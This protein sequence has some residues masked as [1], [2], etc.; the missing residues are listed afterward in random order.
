MVRSEPSKLVSRS[1]LPSIS[2]ITRGRANNATRR[3]AVAYIPP[4]KQPILPA[5]AT[6]I[7]RVEFIPLLHR[8]CSRIDSRLSHSPPVDDAVCHLPRPALRG[9]RVRVRG[10]VRTSYGRRVRLEPAHPKFA[11][12]NFD[13]S[14]QAGRGEEGTAALSRCPPRLVTVTA[15]SYVSPGAA[16]AQEPTL[17]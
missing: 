10:C 8:F 11:S 6:P 15:G 7:G 4:T 9:E 5:P 3:P 2:P 16:T 12:P 14:P 13:L 17:R 1:P